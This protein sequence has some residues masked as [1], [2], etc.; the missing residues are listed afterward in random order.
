MAIRWLK[1]QSFVAI[2]HNIVRGDKAQ[3]V[4]ATNKAQTVI[5]RGDKAQL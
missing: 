5:A 3:T 4:I 1:A 2:R